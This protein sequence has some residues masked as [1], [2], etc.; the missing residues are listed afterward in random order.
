MARPTGPDGARSALLSVRLTPK[1]MF[2]LEMMSRLHRASIPDIV[3]RA[4]KDVFT[5]EFEGLWDYP[6]GSANGAEEEARAPR[7]LLEVLWAD[8]P[9]D[10]FANIALHCAGL[11]SS[12]DIRLWAFIYAQEKFWRPDCA[13]TEENLLREVLAMEW[14]ALQGT[15]NV[16]EVSKKKGLP[17]ALAKSALRK[18]LS[19][20][21]ERIKLKVLSQKPQSLEQA[22]QAGQELQDKLIAAGLPVGVHHVAFDKKKDVHAY[23]HIATGDD[24]DEYCVALDEVL[25]GHIRAQ[26]YLPGLSQPALL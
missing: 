1:L 9:S 18:T 17:P 22:R 24:P 14:T 12:A 13:R 15:H 26:P 16:L 10:R 3:S 21:V 25:A 11:M 20:E 2:G 6:K 4:I 5:S 19:Q 8:R 23:V 7:Y